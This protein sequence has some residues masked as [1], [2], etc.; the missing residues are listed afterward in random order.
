MNRIKVRHAFSLMHAISGMS[1]RNGKGFARHPECLVSRP[2]DIGFCP[3]FQSPLTY[4]FGRVW[5]HILSRGHRIAK[6]HSLDATEAG[7]EQKPDHNQI[8]RIARHL[9]IV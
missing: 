6:D 2:D 3:V 4:A 9:Q 5:P 7:I 1:C 8:W